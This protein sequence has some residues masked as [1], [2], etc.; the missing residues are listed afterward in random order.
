MGFNEEAIGEMLLSLK[1]TL[2]FHTQKT[3]EPQRENPCLFIYLK[4]VKDQ[5]WGF[6]ESRQE[7]S[8]EQC[9][10]I[11]MWETQTQENPYKDLFYN[12]SYDDEREMWILKLWREKEKGWIGGIK[13]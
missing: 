12:L 11:L 13:T 6:R 10:M 9:L 8:K 1:N 4:Q 7:Y 5:K 2:R 3:R